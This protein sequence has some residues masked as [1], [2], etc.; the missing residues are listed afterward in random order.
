MSQKTYKGVVGG[1]FIEVRFA[2]SGLVARI[3]RNLGDVVNK[4]DIL[5]SLDR[6]NLQTDLDRELANY[7]KV[8]AEF[9]IFNLQNPNINS[10]LLKYEKVQKQAALNSSVKAVELSKSQLDSADLKSPIKGVV[11]DFNKLRVGMYITP[12]SFPITIW[13]SEA[14]YLGVEIEWEDIKDF[15]A[16]SERLVKL[17]TQE[18]AVKGT[19]QPILPPDG[20]T[21]LMVKIL[22]PNEKM[23]FPGVKG[24]I[25]NLSSKIVAPLAE[26]TI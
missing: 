4:G 24:E 14:V 15:P 11:T 18:E 19:V 13:D 3:N 2:F 7:E 21:P 1:E 20:K 5:A 17:E 6:K 23:V 25:T 26:P 22:L 9:E 8:R 10:D 16:G 12:G